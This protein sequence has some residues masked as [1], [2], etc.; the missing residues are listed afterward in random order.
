[1]FIF[2]LTQKRT[3]KVK[4]HKYLNACIEKEYASNYWIYYI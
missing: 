3:K 2:G 1:M 4:T